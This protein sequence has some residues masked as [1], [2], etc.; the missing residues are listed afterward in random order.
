M[1]LTVVEVHAMPRPREKDVILYEGL[2]AHSLENRSHLLANQT[3][4][5]HTDWIGLIQ[6]R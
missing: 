2:A 5:D 3:V 1:G 6:V 4:P